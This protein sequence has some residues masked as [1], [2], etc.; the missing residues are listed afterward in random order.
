MLSTTT[1]GRLCMWRLLKVTQR[2][3]ASCWRTPERT[4][5]SRT[6]EWKSVCILKT[7]RN[8]TPLKHNKQNT[9]KKLEHSSTCLWRLRRFKL[10]RNN[11]K[12][13]NGSMKVNN[14]TDVKSHRDT[15]TPRPPVLGE[16]GVLWVVWCS[17]LLPPGGGALRCRRP[18]G[19][20]E[21]LQWSCCRAPP[22]PSDLGPVPNRF[23]GSSRHLLI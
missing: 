19:T 5:P 3:S 23:I 2:S 12:E 8:K 6:G 15:T 21:P 10:H 22:D 18:W 4:P 16:G 14:L 20:T 9:K 13:E 1:A 17:S 7:E 11:S